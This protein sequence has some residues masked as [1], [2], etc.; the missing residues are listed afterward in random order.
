MIEKNLGYKFTDKNLLCNALKHSSLKKE[1]LEFERLEFL[2]DRVLGVIIADF[3]YNE[4]KRDNEGNMACKFASAVNAKS[5]YKIALSIGLNHFIQTSNNKVLQNNMTVLA[6][7]TEALIGALFLDAG[8][9]AT[10]QIVIGL[11]RKLLFHTDIQEPKTQL[12]ETTQA[13]YKIIP[14]Y[15]VIS[16]SGPE[17]APVFCV[18]V[19]VME[20]TAIGEGYSKK[21]AETKAAKS[22]LEDLK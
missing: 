21:D 1:G 14:K 9:K 3:L 8:F 18:E 7:A 22:M 11:W 12:Q 20:K 16:K 4:F 10:Q 2:G 5:C 6:D 19:K 17:H 13:R 15:T